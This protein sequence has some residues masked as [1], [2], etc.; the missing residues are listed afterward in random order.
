VDSDLGLV[1]PGDFRPQPIVKTE[2]KIKRTML[3]CSL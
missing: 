3:A 2:L 1:S